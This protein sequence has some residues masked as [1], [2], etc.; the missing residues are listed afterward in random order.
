MPR[1]SMII[2]V[3]DT[4]MVMAMVMATVMDQVAAIIM[5][6]TTM[7]ITTRKSTNTLRVI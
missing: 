7:D 1:S 3:M 6:T 2:M 5:D 4:A